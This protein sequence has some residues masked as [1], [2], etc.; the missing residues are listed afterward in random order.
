MPPEPARL[1]IAQ[2]SVPEPMSLSAFASLRAAV[3]GQRHT[4]H[5]LIDILRRSQLLRQ[6]LLQTHNP[7]QEVAETIIV[8]ALLQHLRKP[9]LSF[10]PHIA[11]HPAFRP[12]RNADPPLSH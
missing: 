12:P 11:H 1:A 2:T 10:I 7:A 5:I 4:I 3:G 6:R 9:G 8:A